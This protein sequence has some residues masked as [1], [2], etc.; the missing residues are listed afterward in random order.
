MAD[1]IETRITG[2]HVK[3]LEKYGQ[4]GLRMAGDP[5]RD[6]LDYAINELVGL[7]RYAEMIRA[8]ASELPGDPGYSEVYYKLSRISMSMERD[9]RYLAQDLIECRN[10][11]LELGHPLGEPEKR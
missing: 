10:K 11:L 3:A 6:I 4:V 7:I 2:E 1:N 9:G 5:N 8:R